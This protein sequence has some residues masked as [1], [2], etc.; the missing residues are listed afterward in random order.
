MCVCVFVYVLK[1]YLYV[2][3]LFV[4]V[5]A[6]RIHIC[7]FV[8]M[9]VCVFVCVCI[10][11]CLN[12]CVLCL[13]LVRTLWLCNPGLAVCGR[14]EAGKARQPL[15][16]VVIESRNTDR[17]LNS[18]RSN[19][20]CT[21]TKNFCTHG[22]FYALRKAA[23]CLYTGIYILAISGE[24]FLNKLKNREEFEGGL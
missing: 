11:V 6:K 1:R 15:P 21:Q 23:L 16:M 17:P 13:I 18:R 20:S 4:C 22:F 3:L 12:I 8:H 14:T 2:F 7:V 10:L 5:C 19:V 24:E 9:C